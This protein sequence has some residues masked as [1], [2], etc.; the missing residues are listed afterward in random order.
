MSGFP[1]RPD[2]PDFWVI[3]EAL[4][5]MDAQ[6]DQDAPFEDMVGWIVSP[7][8]LAYVAFQRALRMS[9]PVIGPIAVWMDGFIAG[10]RY[11]H[12]RQE[13]EAGQ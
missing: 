2:H 4:I 1:G 11:Q 5:E 6:A 3:S 13:K 9:D 7:A 8:V 12:K 10:A